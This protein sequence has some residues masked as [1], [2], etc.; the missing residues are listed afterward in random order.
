MLNIERDLNLIDLNLE[1]VQVLAIEV[2]YLKSEINRLRS[3][4]IATEFTCITL[5]NGKDGLWA[6]FS[7]PAGKQKFSLN[8]SLDPISRHFA[9][10]Y[11][12]KVEG[13]TDRILYL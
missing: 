9:I 3:T 10:E 12:T 13:S 6:H 2:L 8:L 5:Q 11:I 7:L 1:V 4:T